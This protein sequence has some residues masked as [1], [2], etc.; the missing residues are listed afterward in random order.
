[1]RLQLL[2]PYSYFIELFW[3][4][5]IVGEMWLAIL[6]LFIALCPGVLF[7][8]PRFGIKIFMK[9]KLDLLTIFLHG[10]LFVSIV[11]IL[12]VSEAF[13][14]APVNLGGDSSWLNSINNRCKYDNSITDERKATLLAAEQALSK[15]IQ[16][17]TKSYRDAYSVTTTAINT[18]EQPVFLK[19]QQETAKMTKA[20]TDK[21]KNL[22][23]SH[24]IISRLFK[25]KQTAER[26]ILSAETKKR[27]AESAYNTLINGPRPT[28]EAIQAALK[29][30]NDADREYTGLVQQNSGLINTYKTAHNAVSKPIEDKIKSERKKLE[31]RLTAHRS[32][33]KD[34]YTSYNNAYKQLQDAENTA[35]KNPVNATLMKDVALARYNLQTAC[36]GTTTRA[37]SIPFTY[38]LFGVIFTDSGV[39]IPPVIPTPPGASDPVVVSGS[40]AASGVNLT[41]L[42][43]AALGSPTPAQ[44]CTRRCMPG[45]GNC[46]AGGCCGCLVDKGSIVAPSPGFAED[47]RQTYGEPDPLPPLRVPDQGSF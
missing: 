22:D 7:T 27:N 21:I 29:R 28:Q 19:V 35:R 33:R 6:V 17:Q 32:K 14:S 26:K 18:Y 16:L 43:Q 23:K 38:S 47:P 13:Q 42:V 1:M 5:T 39:S 11:Q 12:R 4:I 24:P 9:G 20:N 30:K 40:P 10:L 34:L 46:E 31:G 41:G 45:Y 37:T 2:E 36:E 15:S 44:V 3:D 25:R 8:G